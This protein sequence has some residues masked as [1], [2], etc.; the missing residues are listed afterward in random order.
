[1][2]PAQSNSDVFVHSGVI[3]KIR[4]NS[5]IVSLKENVHCES[6]RAKGVCGV[7]DSGSKQIEVFNSNDS[8]MLN[9]NVNIIL[10]KELGFKAVVWAY[11]IPF[12]LLFVVMIISSKYYEEWV[13]GLLAL[14]VLIPYYFVLYFLKDS[15]RKVFNASIKKT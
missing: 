7:S 10:K 13:A 15:F 6:C 8:F 1:M 4:G 3:S 11:I 2:T 12:F 5:V 9:E 14:G